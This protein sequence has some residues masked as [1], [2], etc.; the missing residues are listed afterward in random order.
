MAK[1]YRVI[2]IKLK[3][4]KKMSIQ[5]LTYQQ[6]VFK[7]YHSDRHFSE[8][9]PT[10]RRQKST[11]ID[12][13]QNYVTDTQ[14]ITPSYLNRFSLSHCQISKFLVMCF[15]QIPSHVINVAT[16]PC[17]KLVLENKRQSRKDVVIN[18]VELRI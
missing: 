8:F 16:L 13:K 6:S 7:S 2:E 12:M 15:L 9:L 1:I 17:E 3:Q 10:R 4:F 18:K 11:G 5:S 14:F